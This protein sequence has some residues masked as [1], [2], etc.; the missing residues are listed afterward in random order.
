MHR[1]TSRRAL[2]YVLLTPLL[3][4]PARAEDRA[5]A[6]KARS[7]LSSHC[8]ACHGPGGTGKGGFAFVLDRDRLVSRDFVR[9]GKP[10]ESLLWQ[11]VDQ[12][13]M[14]PPSSKKP[15]P[16]AEELAVLRR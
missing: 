6:D 13:E 12:K 8:G 7:I 1:S 10:A 11:R 14:P 15:A 9:P 2:A 5:L 16:S 3:T 4:T